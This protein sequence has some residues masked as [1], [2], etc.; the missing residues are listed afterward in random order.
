MSSFSLYFGDLYPQIRVRDC[1]KVSLG[2]IMEK[3]PLKD[4]IHTSWVIRNG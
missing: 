4:V 3:T 1:P 2:E